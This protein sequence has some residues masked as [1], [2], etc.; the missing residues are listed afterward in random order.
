M[1]TNTNNY[2][3]YISVED[4]TRLGKKY[5]DVFP[6][7]TT[8]NSEEEKKNFYNKMINELVEPVIKS[9]NDAIK[10]GKRYLTEIN[11]PVTSTNESELAGK[12]RIFAL[13]KKAHE[14]LGISIKAYSNE[15][16]TDSAGDIASKVIRKRILVPEEVLE[17]QTQ[18]IFN[19]Y[20]DVLFDIYNK[21]E[22]KY[23][24]EVNNEFFYPEISFSEPSSAQKEDL[25]RNEL[26]SNPIFANITITH[27]DGTEFHADR[28]TLAKKSQ[29]FE[30]L[31]TAPFE[32]SN[33]IE[34]I[35]LES[36]IDS[37]LF[38][39]YLDFLYTKTIKLS[40]NVEEIIALASFADMTDVEDLKLL[41]SQ[42]LRLL[43]TKE[44]FLDIVDYAQQ[45]NDELLK[46]RCILFL[47]THPK[48]LERNKEHFSFLEMKDLLNMLDIAQFVGSKE[49]EE[50]IYPLIEKKIDY[51]N[52]KL[53]CNKA[54]HFKVLKKLCENFAQSDSDFLKK[55]S[56][57]T[58]EAY[59]QLTSD[60]S[61]QLAKE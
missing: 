43:L 9:L 1:L 58:Q 61:V 50:I 45:T 39:Q 2:K 19:K 23:S 51:T 6:I 7:P 11:P 25:K 60:V 31:L 40:D 41:C 3:N 54:A 15:E 8:I 21:S 12:A 20:K 38:G 53:V 33:N 34:S 16:T 26:R 30:A 44:T 5:L 18:E 14:L 17:N 35:K 24:I 29:F 22:M 13:F 48:W 47:K 46:E 49:F 10:D 57:D 4:C 42:K 59:I 55:A 37:K 36:D 28:M 56:K 27:K 52:F 32:E